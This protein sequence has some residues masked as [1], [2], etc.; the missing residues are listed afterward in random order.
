MPKYE[1]FRRY[2]E[3]KQLW[4]EY[5]FKSHV[6]LPWL[7]NLLVKNERLQEMSRELL[8]TDHTVIWSTDW[9]VKPRS[10][11]QHFTWHQDSTYSK[12]GLNGCTLWLA[13]SHVKASSGPILYRRF[14]QRMGQL[15]H[16]EDASDSSNLLAFGQYIPEDEPTPLILGCLDEM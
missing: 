9:C 4:S 11:P 8:C 3:E 5:R 14:S 7:H 2:C 12:F 16:V 13:F 6:F 1:S 10:S 15:K